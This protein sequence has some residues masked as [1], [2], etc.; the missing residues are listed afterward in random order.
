MM[1]RFHIHEPDFIKPNV[2]PFTE[3]VKWSGTTLIGLNMKDYRDDS[4][5]AIQ[6]PKFI[7]TGF[8]ET[9][10]LNISSTAGL[11]NY[12]HTF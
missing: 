7:F 9:V 2:R 6:V 5:P 4:F 1:Q 12:F 8:E 3:I 10:I 11:S